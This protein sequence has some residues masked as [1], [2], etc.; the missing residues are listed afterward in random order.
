MDVH[1]LITTRPIRGVNQCSKDVTETQQQRPES[2][3]VIFTWYPATQAYTAWS[4]ESKHVL[5]ALFW[6][7]L[8][9]WSLSEPK[10]RLPRNC[11]NLVLNYVSGT[12]DTSKQAG[13]LS[14]RRQLMLT[15]SESKSVISLF[16]GWKMCLHHI[17]KCLLVKTVPL[18]SDGL[19]SRRWNAC[20]LNTSEGI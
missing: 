14:K 19:T 16:H 20:L 1:G 7:I 10:S 18:T 6:F 3:T 9:L 5:W 4:V 15:V 13:F 17:K 2:C 8:L 11:L 12:L